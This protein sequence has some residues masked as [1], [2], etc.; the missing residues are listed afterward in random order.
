MELLIAYLIIF[1]TSS[2]LLTRRNAGYLFILPL[3]IGGALALGGAVVKGISARNASKKK[4]KISDALTSQGNQLESEAWSGKT[5]YKSPEEIAQL[6]ALA[7]SNLNDNSIEGAMKANADIGASNTLTRAKRAATSASDA[8]SMAAAAEA[9]RVAGYNN[10]AVA[11]AQERN[12]DMNFLA[13]TT[14]MIGQ[15]A[16]KTY[17]ANVL[18]PFR[19]R[20]AKSQQLQQAGL[21]G[22]IDSINENTAAW[23]S[24]GNGFIDA[25]TAL[26]GAPGGMGKGK[27]PSLDQIRANEGWYGG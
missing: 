19:L 27:G 25:G 21:Q 8:A 16:D 11:G 5:D 10:A 1:S 14:Q 17:N 3:L 22:K 13:Q 2:A 12:T 20:Y 24:I 26:M 9:Q 4:R 7:T 23:A 15:E 6:D 18:L